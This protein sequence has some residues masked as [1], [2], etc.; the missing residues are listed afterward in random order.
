[1]LDPNNAEKAQKEVIP[2]TTSS[3]L[4][5]FVISFR[6]CEKDW[7]FP[8]AFPYILEKQRQTFPFYKNL[9]LFGTLSQEENSCKQGT[10]MMLLH[11]YNLFLDPN[12][13]ITLNI[14]IKL[15]ISHD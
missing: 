12:P 3:L 15:L 7:D 11:V 9:M 13:D 1:M 8:A 4:D 10:C 6:L 14:P 2:H 5:N